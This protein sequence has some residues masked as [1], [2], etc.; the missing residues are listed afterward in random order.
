MYLKEG[1]RLPY[2][3][4]SLFH[5]FVHE[6]LFWIGIIGRRQ[7]QRS[8]SGRDTMSNVSTSNTEFISKAKMLQ[9]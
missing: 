9:N 5:V 4:G 3:L 6:S 1:V 8:D 2:P 7:V